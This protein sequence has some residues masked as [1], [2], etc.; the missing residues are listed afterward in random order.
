M[1]SGD[2]S[3]LG[4]QWR[5]DI[6]FAGNNVPMQVGAQARQPPA[7]RAGHAVPNNVPAC[8]TCSA[9]CVPES[10]HTYTPCW[11]SWLAQPGC[12]AFGPKCAAR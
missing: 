5:R 8:L 10:V 11:L 4:P 2:L 7:Q 12:E 3:Y 6:A 1:S 9:M